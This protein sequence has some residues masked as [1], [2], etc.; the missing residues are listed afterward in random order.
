MAFNRFIVI[1]FF[2]VIL[3]S[4]TTILF[5]YYIT[6]PERIFTNIFLGILVLIQ[7][8]FLYYYVSR[9][10]RD[11]ARFLIYA[12]EG[13]IRTNYPEKI[14]STFRDLK[15]S[16]KSI[17]SEFEIIRREK[18][19]KEEYLNTIVHQVQ[20]GIISFSDNQKIDLINNSAIKML[21]VDAVYRLTDLDK[22]HPGLSKI[23]YDLD[24]G[25]QQTIKLFINDSLRVLSLR[26]TR[27]IINN[28]LYHV[29]TI[30]DI[31]TELEANE[32]DS[33]KKLIR[34]IAHEIMNSLTPITTLTKTIKNNLPDQITGKS[35]RNL[36]IDN[37]S[38]ILESTALIDDRSKGLIGFV[39]KYRSLTQL[40]KPILKTI[41]LEN[42]L[43]KIKALC[44]K[45]IKT[46]NIKLG[47]DV[48]PDILS[49]NA[50]DNM[51]KQVFINLF[52]NALQAIS[53][54]EYPEIIMGAR[55]ADDYSIRITIE[56][57]GHGISRENLDKVFLPF[58]TTRDNGSGIGLS[59]SRQILHLHGATI[60]V[61]SK[62]GEGTVFTIN[63]L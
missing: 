45:E 20:T 58:F 2:R 17:N 57:N 35:I 19:Q 47:I 36:N 27:I 33:Y 13:D 54:I 38:D 34:I 30:H 10:N 42:F 21:E 28:Q 11:L 22:S 60:S 55:I 56:D 23:I 9:T 15:D 14:E 63:F 49:I 46:R 53:D 37:I 52:N 12:R 5:S 7:V 4:I 44:Q 18:A 24:S 29:V 41:V 40:P 51:L 6:V 39:E 8:F 43:L 50:D 59:I 32:L 61:S 48:E 26:S 1:I 3:I 31:K 25:K 16:F 62:A